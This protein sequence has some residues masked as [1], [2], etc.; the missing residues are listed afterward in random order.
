MELNNAAKKTTILLA[1]NF[2]IPV[3]DIFL[4]TK[5][6][7]YSFMKA[8]KI[9]ILALLST[10][11][12]SSCASILNGKKQKV[13]IN[14][15][16]SD[17]EVY[18]DDIKLGSGANPQVEIPRDL[19]V[20]NV[21]IKRKGYLDENIPI[22]QTKKS[23]LYIL[24]VVPFGILL[25]PLI[26][27]N[28]PT[29]YNYDREIVFDKDTKAVPERTDDEKFLYINTTG[30]DVKKEEIKFNRIKRRRYRKGKEKYK[31]IP[32]E[33]KEDLEITDTKL[34]S[35][36]HK[37][38]EDF[39]YTDTTRV[40]LR[41]KNKSMFLDAKVVGVTNTLVNDRKSFN[42]GR[43]M[44]TTLTKLDVEWKILDY[45]KVPKH[46]ETI[47]ATSNEFAMD[48]T[49]GS[50]YESCIKDALQRSFLEF[51]SSSKVRELIQINE[52]EDT[53]YD[54]LSLT[55]ATL[56]ASLSEALNASFTVKHKEGHG[57][58][59]A[60]SKEGHIITN[61]H[62]VANHEDELIVVDSNLKEYKAELLRFSPEKDLA[63][64]KIDRAF[65][66]S[67]TIQDK[68][69]YNLGQDIYAIG[70]PRSLELGQSLTKGIISGK[71]ENEGDFFIQIDASV[72]SG[73]SGGPLVNENGELIGVI[74]AKVKGDSIEGLGFAILADEIREALSIK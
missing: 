68:A 66:Y 19:Q 18:V 33:I 43:M 42:G 50:N 56:P 65:D 64:L 63:L 37:I 54:L 16:S 6:H 9:L 52:L 5:L 53:K 36:L 29:A 35:D 2:F 60:I 15:G 47:S 58:G 1:K 62:V 28:A 23:P 25:Y 27:D 12:F 20:K 73:N 57:S 61:Y 26:S 41:K 8:K 32:V 22:Y 17:T 40:L 51:I 11:L 59:F 7:I 55:A 71:R 70:T 49:D 72:N 48:Y 10:F 74:N 46:T 4:K 31:D 34:S 69:T 21:T 44:Q 45:Y 30:F 39:N 67:F 3:K 13:T 14:T 24:S 38:L